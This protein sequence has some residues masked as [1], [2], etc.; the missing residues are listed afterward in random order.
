MQSREMN[1]AKYA[2]QRPSEHDLKRIKAQLA[3]F[4][5]EEARLTLGPDLR[6]TLRML[7][8]EDFWLA[9]PSR[10][11]TYGR[12]AVRLCAMGELPL[13]HVGKRGNTNLYSFIPIQPM[14][15]KETSHAH[16]QA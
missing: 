10:P 14:T 3:I 6:F 1:H 16:R 9:K 7:C 5:T 12:C 4:C 11:S 2:S 13:R 8:G 15:R